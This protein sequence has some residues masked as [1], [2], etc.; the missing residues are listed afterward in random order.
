MDMKKYYSSKV[1]EHKV[2]VLSSSRG[3]ASQIKLVI[4]SLGYGKLGDQLLVRNLNYIFMGP[5][6]VLLKGQNGS[7]KSTLLEI[8]CG[9]REPIKGK[10]QFDISTNKKDDQVVKNLIA[11]LPQEVST[12]KGDLHENLTLG[13]EGKVDIEV[14]QILLNGFKFL[15]GKWN[16]KDKRDYRTDLSGG[17]KQ[18]IGLARFFS[19][20][21]WIMIM[22]EPTSALDEE[23]IDYLRS[24]ILHRKKESLFIITSHTSDF[25]DIADDTFNL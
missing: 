17:E 20:S 10:L 2:N 23:S 3:E 16:L 4:D 1:P 14:A 6:L 22:D 12:I 18:K 19:Q 13:S 24:M 7:G 11:Y 15:H 8:M 5:G 21:S 25:D 9:L